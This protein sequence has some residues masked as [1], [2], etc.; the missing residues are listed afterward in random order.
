MKT[1]GGR[2]MKDN[3]NRYLAAVYTNS[4]A[5][6]CSLHGKRRNLKLSETYAMKLFIGEFYFQYFVVHWFRISP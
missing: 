6:N 1:I 2:D 4:L 5:R 3:I